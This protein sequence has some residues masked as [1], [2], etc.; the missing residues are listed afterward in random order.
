MVCASRIRGG[1]LIAFG[2]FIGNS[3]LANPE[4]DPGGGRR[5]SGARHGGAS[6][7]RGEASRG[8]PGQSRMS[9]Y[10]IILGAAVSADGAPSGTLRRRI[11][12]A[13]S[14][15]K[16]VRAARFMPTGGAGPNGV[17]EAD[18]ISRILI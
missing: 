1:L 14:A 7:S 12:G 2:F 3:T 17:V 15:A 16:D 8:P 6:C 11:E 13:L 18:V 9:T 10:F 5:R 4:Q